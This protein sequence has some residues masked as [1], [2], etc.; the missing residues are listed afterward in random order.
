MPFKA[1]NY[2]IKDKK[3][4]FEI[5]YFTFNFHDDK[6]ALFFFKLKILYES[7]WS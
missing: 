1:Y 6:S 7:L 4:M 3:E 5:K 2:F